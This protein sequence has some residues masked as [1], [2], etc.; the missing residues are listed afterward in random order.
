MLYLTLWITFSIG[1]LLSISSAP[2]GA[3]RRILP[4]LFIMSIAV[5]S[6]IRW[7]TG[8]D[9][10]TYLAFY[11]S[12]GGFHDYMSYWHFEPGFKFVVWLF[13]YFG[14]GYSL[15]LFILTLSVLVIKFFPIRSRPYVMVCFLVLFGTSMADLFPT[16]EGLA[17]SLVIVSASFLVERRYILYVL[18]VLLASLFHITAIVF[19]LAPLIIAAGYRSLCIVAVCGGILL[20]LFLYSA[21]MS[22]AMHLGLA[23]LL[24]TAEL[25]S[26]TI[27]GRVSLPSIAQKIIILLFSFGVLPKCREQM[28]RFEL[29]AVK[30]MVFGLIGSIFLESGSQ[31]FNRLTIYF[32]SF[33]IIA[34]SALIWFYSKYLISKKYY[35]M[36]LIVF[37]TV[38]TFY[39]VRF[40]GLL[41]SYPDLYYPFETVFQHS[42]RATY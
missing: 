4:G 7:A 30:L 11:T 29:A 19:L 36:L 6:G 37:V 15:W 38:C 24:S 12:G 40:C 17:I 35:F 25:Y 31:I 39:G 32:V 22:V 28:T 9:W 16:R 21:V 26:G 1:Y 20:K 23:D 8:T 42:H 14:A 13:N 18:C 33:E 34:M 41:T 3:I 5:L 27:A 10:D 2:T